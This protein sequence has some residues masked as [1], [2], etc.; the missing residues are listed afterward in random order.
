MTTKIVRTTQNCVVRTAGGTHGEIIP[1]ALIYSN[2]TLVVDTVYEDGWAHIVG[3]NPPIN[4]D[5]TYMKSGKQGWVE[6]AHLAEISQDKTVYQVE[7]DWINK[8]IR[9]V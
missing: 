6:G 2:Q 1:G 7:V 3:P 9:L 5:G 4:V 8:S